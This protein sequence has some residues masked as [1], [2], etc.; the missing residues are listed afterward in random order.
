MKTD[1]AIQHFNKPWGPLKRKNGEKGRYGL[2][3]PFSIDEV[4]RDKRRGVEQPS[5]RDGQIEGVKRFWRK[6]W[7]VCSVPNEKWQIG[8]LDPTIGDSTNENLAM[9]PPIQAQFRDRFKWDRLFQKMW[10]TAEKELI[11]KIDTYYTEAEQRK[12]LE[13]LQTRDWASEKFGTRK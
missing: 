3:F 4:M 9:Q 7:C 8:H 6:H 5:D 13:A 11:P 12:L 1:D 2:E 10:P